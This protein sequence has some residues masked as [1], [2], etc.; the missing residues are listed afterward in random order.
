[1]ARLP[2][3]LVLGL[4]AALTLTAC[5]WLSADD[6]SEERH[7]STSGPSLVFGP[8]PESFEVDVGYIDPER[9]ARLVVECST[10]PVPLDHAAP[11][12][13][14]LGMALV[15]VRSR[16]PSPDRIGTLVLIPGGPGEPG[17]PLAG[18]WA[19]WFA[20]D[21]LDHFDLVTFDPRGTGSSAPINCA[22]TPEDDK[23]SWS[24]DLLTEKGLTQATRV[25]RRLTRACVQRLGDTAPY[26][27]TTQTARDVD[28]L[29]EALGE[30]ELTALGWSYG[31]KLGAE[32]ARQFPDRVR[33]L[34]LDAPSDSAISPIEVGARQIHG[35]ESSLG[36][37]ADQCPQRPGCAEL[38]EPVRFVRDLV[39]S[40]DRHP[41]RSSR[42]VDRLPATGATVLDAVAAMLYDGNAWDRLDEAL[43]KASGGD[44]AGLFEGIEHVQGPEVSDDPDVPEPGDARY[45]INC[46]DLPPRPSVGEIRA[47]AR[48]VVRENP[49][50]GRWG[51]WFLLGCRGWQQDRTPLALPEA[52][53]APPIVVIGTVHDPA[54]PY[55]GAVHIAEVLGSGHLL[56]WEGQGH[57]A[58]GTSD[59]VT[60]LADDYL[61]TLAL[62]EEGTRCPVA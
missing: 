30:E 19:S 8:C 54:T 47:T 35:F 43:L 32:Y 26:F 42:P 12:G 21:V 18:W 16:N 15:R 48:R 29:R 9:Y 40:A 37:W 31:A 46:N 4:A 49:V 62:P 2:G 14:R 10:L 60:R 22:R 36:E 34:V 57:T 20:D 55:A 33:A 61:I 13:R 7:R 17:L 1:M 44:A 28:L 58:Y 53:S 11:G 39:A 23:P 52:P 6:G 56:T 24:V 51:S 27:N 41:I 38:G 3:P 45:V 5:S 25:F 50:F 59:C